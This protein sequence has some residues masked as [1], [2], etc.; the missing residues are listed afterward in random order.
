MLNTV[1]AKSVAANLADLWSPRVIG[2]VDDFYIKV[3]KVKGTFGRHAHAHEDE[4]FFVLQGSLRLIM[5]AGDVVLNEGDM[6]VVPKGVSHNPVA[7]DECLVLLV[8]RKSTLHS[9]DTK[10]AYT[11]SIE[12]QLS[13]EQS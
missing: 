1:N 2:E 10:N 13:D 7:E 5:D 9:G 4:M 11:R 12:E 3:A 8:E 6:H